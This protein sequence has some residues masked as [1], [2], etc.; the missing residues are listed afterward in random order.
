LVLSPVIFVRLSNSTA[1]R[2][3]NDDYCSYGNVG[4]CGCAC[5]GWWLWGFTWQGE[6]GCNGGDVE[7]AGGAVD[8]GC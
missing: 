3:D 5:T 6:I 2:Y 4:H 8:V 7:L 1:A